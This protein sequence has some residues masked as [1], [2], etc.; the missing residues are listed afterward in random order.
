MNTILLL[1]GL[2]GGIVFGAVY[3]LI[4]CSLNVLCGV[5]RIVNFAH[6]EFIIAGTFF[7]YVLLTVLGLHP[8]LGLPV[9]ATVF[10]VAGYG[11][12]FVLI[13]RLARSDEP[14]TSSFLLMFGVSLMMVA[15]MLWIFEADVR[16][17]NFS[18]DPINVSLF[19]IPEAYGPGRDGRVVVPTARLVALAVNAVIIVGL[20]WFLYRTLSGKAMRAAIMNR[21]AVQIVCINVERLSASAFGLA[22]GLA[23]VTGGLLALVIPSIDP[24]GGADLTLI[25]FIVIVLGGLGHPV[26]AL[27]AGILFGLVEQLATVLMPQAAAQMIGFVILIAVIFLRPQGLFGRAALR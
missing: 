7:S 3:A 2:V 14:E 23:G 18:F 5:L 9:V 16:P 27:V 12:Y 15:I 13:P 6:G 19:T 22:A 20:T 10:F 17:V 8:L 25:G 26:G 11:L 1:N 24:N 4:G 21:E